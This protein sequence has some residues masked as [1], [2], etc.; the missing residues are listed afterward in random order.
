MLSYVNCCC[1]RWKVIDHKRQVQAE[2]QEVAKTS[3]K[4]LQIFKN[5]I[6]Y[7]NGNLDDV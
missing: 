5:C 7:I 4:L 6:H 2:L 3:K 1:F